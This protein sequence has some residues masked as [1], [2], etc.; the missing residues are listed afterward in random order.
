MQEALESKRAFLEEVVRAEI[1]S[2]FAGMEDMRAQMATLQAQQK[3]EL[4][5]SKEE[6]GAQ[7]KLL[8]VKVK[9]NGRAIR[10]QSATVEAAR[11]IAEQVRQDLEAELLA[12]SK[13]QSQA[14]E[15][16]RASFKTQMADVHLQVSPYIV[17]SMYLSSSY[18]CITSVLIL[19]YILY[20][21]C[22][23]TVYI[24]SIYVLILTVG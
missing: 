9:A 6:V 3:Q 11:R 21:Y 5:E 23:Y 13:T 19:L 10:N 1:A 16:Q 18:K 14:E 4:A 20:I 17:Y 12:M 15:Q 24:Y 2:R 7:L 22:I 8:Q